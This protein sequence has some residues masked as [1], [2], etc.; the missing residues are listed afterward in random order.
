MQLFSMRTVV[1]SSLLLATVGCAPGFEAVEGEAPDAYATQKIHGGSAPNAWYH[2]AV[3][4]LHQLQGNTV[5]T[6]PFCTGT[7]ITDT[8]VLTAG[9]CLEGTSSNK[10]AI[11][12]GDNPYVDLVEHLYTVDDVEVYP[13]YNS[14]QITDDIALIR[15]DNAV[16]ENVTPVY[17]LPD[18]DGFTSSDIGDSM[19]F[20]GF[21]VTES[22]SAG[23]KLQVT[24]PLSGFGC[25]VYGCSSS[26]D[27]ATQISYVQGNGGPCSGDSG[28]PAFVA[29]GDDIY[30]AGVTSYG[31]YYCTQYGVSTR[32]DAYTSWISSFAGVDF[33]AGYGT[34]DGGSDGGDDGG[35]D[36]GTDGGDDGGTDGG[37]TASTC[38][39][40]TYAYD[41]SLSGTGVTI[42][43]PD[44][45]YYH[46]DSRGVHEGYLAGPSSVDFDLYLY[47]YANSG[48]RKVAT[49]QDA[50]SEEYISYTGNAGY[51]IWA[52][53]SYSGAGNYEFCLEVP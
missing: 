53:Y 17:P 2:D 47:K 48:W 26:G 40:F 29:R 23:E 39:G 33:S 19:N 51:Y 44:G 22:G 31:D 6:D 9:H 20:A 35:S 5:Y 27:T 28:G 4:S 7:L 38:D 36:G 10:V 46:S 41:G 37:S 8:V 14:R 18:T 11:Y 42:Y 15:L 13:Y 12:V 34:D 43:E 32:V 1:L 25:S 30:V 16:T 45:D 3:V 49:S 21:G 52:V 50:A 24:I